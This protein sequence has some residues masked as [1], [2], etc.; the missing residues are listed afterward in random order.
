[1]RRGSYE[2]RKECIGN[3]RRREK[4]GERLSLIRL[5]GL[6]GKGIVWTFDSPRL[7]IHPERGGKEDA[8]R[9]KK[10]FGRMEGEKALLLLWRRGLF[11]HEKGRSGTF[12][13]GKSRKGL[14]LRKEEAVNSFRGEERGGGYTF[15]GG[16]D[17][18]LTQ[19]P[20]QSSRGGREN[21]IL[22]PRKER[23]KDLPSA[24]REEKEDSTIPHFS[25]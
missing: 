15:A 6:E 14:R 2:T 20:L 18:Y 5:G 8:A 17:L 10:K 9:K 25:T 24:H 16:D 13:E 3:G 21:K 4:R 1:V 12:Y 11:S 7:D 19:D 23:G 22:I